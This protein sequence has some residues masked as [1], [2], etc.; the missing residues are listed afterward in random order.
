[1]PAHNEEK[2]IR[3]AVRKLI[4]L[5]YL[6]WRSSSSMTDHKIIRSKSCSGNFAF[7][8]VHT[9]Y[10]PEVE[11]AP[12]RGLYRSETHP[13]LVVV[14]KESAG[15]KADA[16]NA[17]L[18][19]ATSPYVCIVDADSVLER[20]ALLRIMLPVVQDPVRVVAVGGIVRVLN[21]SL[22]EEGHLRARLPRKSI[23]VI[24]VIEYLRAF[25]I[26]REAWAQGN[27]FT[28]ISRRFRCI[29]NGFGPCCRRLP[30]AC[31]WRR[32]RL[33]RA[34]PSL[35][36]LNWAPTIESARARSRFLDGSAFRPRIAWKAA[37]VLAERAIGRTV[38]QPGHAHASPL[39]QN[40][41]LCAS[42]PMAV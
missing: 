16:V 41:L 3:V 22:I 21:G 33:G 26:G 35:L 25:L 42:I 11:S 36:T 2:S 23:E 31:D 17:G 6:N 40:R 34:S 28:I 8:T 13:T 1:M 19:A 7:R 5:D 9:L 32:R 4:E 24:Q 37:Q 14:D 27:M 39:R 30:S 38:D 15:S 29:S 10:I 20:D 12:V 18:N